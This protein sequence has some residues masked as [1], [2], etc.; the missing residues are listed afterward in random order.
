MHDD[1]EERFPRITLGQF[2]SGL[3]G[4]YKQVDR[5]PRPQDI[6]DML[7][8]PKA[9]EQSRGTPPAQD[10]QATGHEPTRPSDRN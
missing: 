5:W 3:F 9:D 2:L 6:A 1:D 8:V 7:D 10:G 4:A